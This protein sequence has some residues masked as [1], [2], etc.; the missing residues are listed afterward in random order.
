MSSDARA[1]G[2]R[3]PD[4]DLLW[5]R[6]DRARRRREPLTREAIVAAAVALADAEGLEAVSMRRVAAKLGAGTM[7]LYSYVKRKEDLLE[8]MVDELAR[9]LLV[10]GRLPADWRPALRTIARRTYDMYMRH[11][12]FIDA[13][14]PGTGVGPN[15]LRHFDQSLQAVADLDR[16]TAIG[17]LAAVDDYTTGC[18]YRRLVLGWGGGEADEALRPHIE[19]MVASG[20][21]SNVARFMGAGDPDPADT[22]VR[23]LDW[24]LDGIAAELD[25]KY[26]KRP[27]GTA[28]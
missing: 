18:A 13:A 22:F 20:E 11:P 25:P 4:P 17:V 28:E 1:R 2:R 9:E 14:G 24:L 19:R 23:G 8:L 16:D 10:R 27:R 15:M 5:D 3:Q 7:T 26:V 12:W 6:P 21:L